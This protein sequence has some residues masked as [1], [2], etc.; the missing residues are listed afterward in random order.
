MRQS[1]IDWLEEQ[2]WFE[3]NP[4]FRVPLDQMLGSEPNV[5]NAGFR[6]GAAGQV[7]DAI[8]QAAQSV[9]DGGEDPAEALAA[10]K[11]RADRAIE[12]YNSVIEG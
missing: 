2:G 12:E 5:A 6:A 1:S 8:V 10:A 11:E 3:E 7:R 4:A 9:I